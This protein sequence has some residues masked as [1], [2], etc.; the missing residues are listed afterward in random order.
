MGRGPSTDGKGE[1]TY[2][3]GPTTAAPMPPPTHPDSHLYGTT[4]LPNPVEKV[5]GRVLDLLNRE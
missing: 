5:A 3:N 2:H 4:E 1:F